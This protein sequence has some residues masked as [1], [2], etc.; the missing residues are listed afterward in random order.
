MTVEKTMLAAVFRQYGG[1]EVV[2]HA[3]LPMPVPKPGE[4]LVR[5]HATTVS[6]ADWRVRSLTLPR[7]LGWAG[8]LMFGV[9]GPRKQILGTEFSGIVEA[10][11]AEVTA[12][13]PGEAVIGF[14]GGDL[15]AHA[16]FVVMPAD[17]KILRKPDNLSF[18]EAAAVPFGGTT[19]YDFLFNKGGLQAGER[20][21]VNGASG[22][23]GSAFVQMAARA[24]AR[25]T[26]VCSAANAD[27]VTGLGAEEVIDYTRQDFAAGGARFDV[28]IDT[29]GTAPWIRARQ[30]LVPGGRMLLVAGNASDM[31]F[32]ALKARRD[33][34]RLIAG[35][36]SEAVEVLRAVVDMAAEGQ[37]RP[38]IDRSYPFS[39]IEAAH[40]HVDSGHKRGSVVVRLV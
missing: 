2:R 29:V 17:G 13:A 24:G 36:A 33:G 3:D 30:A 27:L 34:K 8:R 20:V 10:V 14:P 31:L 32:G 25:V 22:A 4:V 15:G 26:G 6:S 40:R 11:G 28:L 35:V 16:E 38:V 19:A 37:F 12:F 5:V 1:P 39:E 18:E 7:G 21:L 23:T 9:F